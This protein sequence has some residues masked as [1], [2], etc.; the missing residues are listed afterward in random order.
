MQY[1]NQL[2]MNL[3]SLIRAKENALFQKKIIG[4]YREEVKKGEIPSLIFPKY[5]QEQI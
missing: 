3:N 1:Q 2:L 4:P 5:T